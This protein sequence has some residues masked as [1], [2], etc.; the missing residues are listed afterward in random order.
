MRLAPG[1]SAPA[2]EAQGPNPG[3]TEEP[4][5]AAGASDYEAHGD[6]EG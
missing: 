5:D 6:S 1:G 3:P 4:A 2:G